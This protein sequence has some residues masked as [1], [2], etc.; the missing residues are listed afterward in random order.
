[1]AEK[2][3]FSDLEKENLVQGRVVWSGL[4]TG[5]EG[6]WVS[7]PNLADKTIHAYSAGGNWNSGTMTL[8]GSNEEGTPAHPITLVDP[9][10]NQI[11]KT[12]DFMEVVLE[13]PAKIRPI[14]T[15]GTATDIVVIIVA[16]GGLR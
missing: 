12:D 14:V 6:E 7:I 11:A 13:N 9:Q 16:K 3:V 4:A 15:G 2:P 10:G 1:M 5:D 8:Q